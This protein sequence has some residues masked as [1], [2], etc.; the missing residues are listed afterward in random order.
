MATVPRYE[1]NVQQQAFP[2]PRI[3]TSAPIEAFGGGPGLERAQN[4]LSGAARAAYDFYREEKKKADDIV[5]QDKLSAAIRK[6]NEVLYDPQNGAYWRKG[7]NAF[8]L[9]ESHFTPFQKYLRELEGDMDA[10]QRALFRRQAAHLEDET[11]T[12]IMK[13]I[14]VQIGDY[15]EESSKNYQEVS[16]QK[17]IN[18][19]NAIGEDRRQ[20]DNIKRSIRANGIRLGKDAAT[21]EA[22][23]RKA[24]HEMY[25]GRVKAW[26]ND[27]MPEYAEQELARHGDKINSPVREQLLEDVGRHRSDKLGRQQADDLWA[28]YSAKNPQDAL[29]EAQRITD[30]K[31]RESAVRRVQELLKDREDRDKGRID[32]GYQELSNLILT[33][34]GKAELPYSKLS[35]QPPENQRALINFRKSMLDGE[36]VPRNSKAYYDARTQAVVSPDKFVQ[37]N[38]R[39][40]GDK[41]HPTELNELIDLQTKLIKGEDSKELDDHR[42]KLQIE[43]SLLDAAGF[44]KDKHAKE[45]ETLRS[46]AAAQERAVQAQ[47]GK[48]ATNEDYERIFKNLVQKSVVKRYGLFGFDALKGDLEKPTGLLTPED[49]DINEV[50]EVE[51][52][53]ASEALKRRGDTVTDEAIIELYIRKL[54]RE[55]MRRAP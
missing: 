6:Q 55:G 26:L 15:D 14:G 47:T 9:M 32:A 53:K 44:D 4:E 2:N 40:L 11:S 28:R 45:I 19:R 34:H 48:K 16:L 42:T 5:V 27:D 1:G 8:G 36:V 51:R 43:E 30:E 50:P 33:S 35:Q 29:S 25:A 18:N 54:Q 23:V 12:N 10:D 37:R 21:V 20:L 24:E 22:E 7:K 39:A 3:D 13:H 31:I 17:G 38:L 49:L 41:I 46:M 52:Q